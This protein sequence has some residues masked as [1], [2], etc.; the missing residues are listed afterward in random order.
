LNYYEKWRPN[1]QVK[2]NKQA[3]QTRWTRINRYVNK[4]V[5]FYK[6]IECRRE[7]GLNEDDQ[8]KRAIELYNNTKTDRFNLLHALEIVRNE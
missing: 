4:F 7:S 2:R 3:L 8:R 1:N 6:Q 5:G